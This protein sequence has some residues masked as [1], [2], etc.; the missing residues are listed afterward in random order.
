MELDFFDCNASFGFPQNPP[1][2]F[3]V[4]EASLVAEMDFVGIRRALAWHASMRDGSPVDGNACV[5]RAVAG[6]DRLV[7]TW[8]ILP[9]ETG[10][11]PP[12]EEFLAQMRANGVRALWS[13]HREHRFLLSRGGMGDLLALIEERRVP[14]FMTLNIDVGAYDNWTHAEALL[15]DF[16][17]LTL[18]V[19][20]VSDWGQDR[21]FRPLV[22]TYERLHIG[23]ESYQLPGGVREFCKRCGSDRLLFGSGYPRCPMG[24]A[25]SLLARADVSD[26][27][28]RAIAC[29]NLERILAEARL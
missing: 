29:G 5:L 24:G 12:P 9:H 14:L 23:I 7:P 10:E 21:F 8:A 26:E 19:I 22:E 16:P 2:R 6:N 11:Q 25:R 28:K 1:P 20:P 18:C 17:V 4:D 3:S 15:R 13:W 27:D